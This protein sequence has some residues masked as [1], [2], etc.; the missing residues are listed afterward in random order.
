MNHFTVLIG[1]IVE[2]KL[3][4]IVQPIYVIYQPEVF[5]SL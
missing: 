3:H 1:R 2:Y 5:S 4:I